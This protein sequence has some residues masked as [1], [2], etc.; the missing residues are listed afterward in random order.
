MNNK[1]DMIQPGKLTTSNDWTD[2]KW[3]LFRDWVKGTLQHSPKVKVTFTKKDGTERIM[4]CTLDPKV[5][6]KQELKE[7]ENRITRQKTDAVVP[8][9]DIE[10]K[11]WRSF[12]LRSVKEVEPYYW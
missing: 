10:A 11:S 6:P 5:L 9:Y 7:G 12:T 3:E 1:I 8:V 2:D 4:W